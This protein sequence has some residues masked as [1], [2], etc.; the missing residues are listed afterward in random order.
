MTIQ[1]QQAETPQP[2]A[3]SLRVTPLDRAGQ[4]LPE[5]EIEITSFWYLHCLALELVSPCRLDNGKVAVQLRTADQDIFLTGR[6][7]WRLVH[8]K[9]RITADDAGMIEAQLHQVARYPRSLIVACPERLWSHQGPL[10]RKD[11][12]TR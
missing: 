3:A 12:R 11:R 1:T 4:P 2:D 8:G 10:P 5:I 7:Y 9:R 6:D